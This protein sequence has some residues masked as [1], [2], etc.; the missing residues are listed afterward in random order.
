[1]I[2]DEEINQILL[3]SPMVLPNSP[4]EAGLKAGAVKEL[5]YK[6]IRALAKVIN[7]QLVALEQ[8]AREDII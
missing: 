4:T 5:F 1:M 8:R 3:S 6:Y 7:I 2:T